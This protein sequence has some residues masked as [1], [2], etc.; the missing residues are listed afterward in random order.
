M[1]NDDKVL[2]RMQEMYVQVLRQNI[3]ISN[4]EFTHTQ[5]FDCYRT[6]LNVR[7]VMDPYTGFLIP[8]ITFNHTVDDLGT[9][10]FRM[11]DKFFFSR[12]PITKLG[13]T[14]QFNDT[15]IYAQ[16]KS[17]GY[18]EYEISVIKSLR[19]SMHM[20]VLKQQETT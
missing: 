1:Y 15:E 13:S 2:D 9:A 6:M 5:S 20:F 17:Y 18:T 3:G 12:N 10:V 14:F 4:F 19:Y 8:M 11:T 7:P 16:L